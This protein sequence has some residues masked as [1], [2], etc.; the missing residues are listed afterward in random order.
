MILSVQGSVFTGFFNVSIQYYR[1]VEYHFDIWPFNNHLLVIPF[2]HRFKKPL[3][4]RYYPVYRPVMLIIFDVFINFSGIVYNLEFNAIKCCYPFQRS[5]NSQTI[6][7]TW[8]QFKL[9]AENKI[10]VFLFGKQIPFT[11][12]IRVNNKNLVLYDII[13]R[14]A[15]PFVQIPPIIQD[16]KPLVLFL[17][18]EFKYPSL[19]LI[20][21]TQ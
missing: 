21:L 11:A 1:S 3:F 4:C 17:F 8:R 2:P 9:K 15:G 19:F 18:A 7:G 16:F 5:P 6:I 13:G 14:I 10:A 12:T 20:K